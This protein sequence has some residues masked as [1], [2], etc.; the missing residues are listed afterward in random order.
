MHLTCAAGVAMCDAVENITGIRPGVKWINDLVYGTR[1]LG[2]ILTELS[3]D[4]ATGLTEY[5]V[6]GI[7]INCN[8]NAEDFSPEL[9]NIATSLSVVTETSIDRAALAGAMIDALFAMDQVLLIGKASIMERYR[10]DCIT[11]GK[12]VVVHRSD[13]ILQ[14]TATGLDED[15]GLLVQLTNGS[16]VT[17]SAGEVSVRGLYGY[18]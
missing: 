5:A 2:G 13:E 6:I 4:T 9:Q 14:G 10:A 1:K 7:G 3:I 15:G 8:R 12:D 18:I 16:T 17:V 11:L